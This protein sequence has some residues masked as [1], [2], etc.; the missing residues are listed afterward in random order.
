[1]DESKILTNTQKKVGGDVLSD[2]YLLKDGGELD[3]EIK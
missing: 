1:M 3:G 2:Q